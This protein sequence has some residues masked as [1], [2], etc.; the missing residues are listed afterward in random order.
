MFFCYKFVFNHKDCTMKET[1][2]CYSC[3]EELDNSVDLECSNCGW[4]VCICGACGCGYS[5]HRRQ[6]SWI[7]AS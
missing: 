3:K 1:K 7:V 6:E 5:G 4:I 2:Q